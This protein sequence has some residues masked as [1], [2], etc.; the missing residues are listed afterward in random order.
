MARR[1]MAREEWREERRMAKR[2]GREKWGGKWGETSP[3]LPPSYFFAL[4]TMA[5]SIFA[6]PKKEFAPR[7]LETLAMH[8][9]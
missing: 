7:P 2:M 4:T 6:R 9:R 1:K 8:A 3:P 5:H